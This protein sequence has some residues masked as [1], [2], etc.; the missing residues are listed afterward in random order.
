MSK[1]T[2]L[3]TLED[4]NYQKFKVE[5]VGDHFVLDGAELDIY[6]L[7][8]MLPAIANRIDNSDTYLLDYEDL[9][10]GPSAMDFHQFKRSCFS[11][12]N[13]LIKWM[14]K[15]GTDGYW[16]LKP[17]VIAAIRH[18]NTT[19]Q[20]FAAHDVVMMKKFFPR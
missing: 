4:E 16:A 19:V 5:R 17:F 13:E 10:S 15:Y 20:A 9:E 2:F 7:L 8:A 6:E 12:T 3:L 18:H 14:D 11:N 1:D